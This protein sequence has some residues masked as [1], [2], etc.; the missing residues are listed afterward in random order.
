MVIFYCIW[1]GHKKDIRE[2]PAQEEKERRKKK[3]KELKKK[4]E[5]L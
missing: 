5:E 2:R 3:E 4:E 1:Y